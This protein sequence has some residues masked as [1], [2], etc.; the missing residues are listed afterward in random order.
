MGSSSQS[1][2]PS[3]VY[4]G[5]AANTMGLQPNV[6]ALFRG[7]PARVA[8]QPAFAL[9]QQQQQ[10]LQQQQ[11]QQLQQQQLQQQQQQQQQQQEERQRQLQQQQ[12]Q[13]QPPANIEWFYADPQG[14]VQ[15]P[16]DSGSMR[17]WLEGGYFKLH[18]PI[19][20]KHWPTFYPLGGVFPDPAEAFRAT[21]VVPELQSEPLGQTPQ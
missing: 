16:F 21:P 20:L 4:Q 9:E 5:G 17:R 13:L 6:A 15:G 10:Q 12:Q 2:P 14:L 8:S 19:K 1:A 3:A 18:L 7:N 11:Q